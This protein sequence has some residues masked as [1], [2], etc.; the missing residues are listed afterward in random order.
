M[1]AQFA[2]QVLGTVILW[3]VSAT[4]SIMVSLALVAGSLARRRTTRAVAS[5]LITVTRGV[6]TSLLVVSAGIAAIAHPSPSWLPNPFPGTS[7]SLALVAW[8]V[9]VALAFGSTG[10]L[11]VIF[12]TGYAALGFARLE[13]T[14][15][16]GLSATARMRLLVRE[17]AGP[18]LA[19]TGARL[20]HHL[21]NT[22]FAALFPVADLFGWVQQR[23]NETFDVSR[24][25]AIGVGGYVVLSLLIWATFRGLEQW[26]APP[27]RPRPKAER[28]AVT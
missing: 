6:P 18:V 15:V 21:H 22:A 2:V 14:T 16:L 4:L 5:S 13:Q 11:A 24:Y 10:H 3:A 25:T 7:A 28:T 12:R 27:A 17:S 9:T 23:A 20:V 26:L 19:P 1:A 8:A